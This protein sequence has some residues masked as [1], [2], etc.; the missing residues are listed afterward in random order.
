M[1]VGMIGIEFG[2]R[3]AVLVPH[4]EFFWHHFYGDK[5]R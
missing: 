3:F 4:I 2:E 1:E 5:F